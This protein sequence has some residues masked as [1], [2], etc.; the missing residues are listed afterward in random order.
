LVANYAS[1]NAAYSDLFPTDAKE[2]TLADMVANLY[3]WADKNGISTDDVL[4]A[5]V[6]EAEIR[7]SEGV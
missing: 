1:L 7:K 3:K 6:R 2:T 5:V 4:L